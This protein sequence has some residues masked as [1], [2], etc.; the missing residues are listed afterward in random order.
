M[1][2]QAHK[3]AFLSIQTVADELNLN[4]ETVRKAVLRGEIPS[5]R[6]GRCYRI[7][8]EALDAWKKEGRAR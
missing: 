6:I 5:V 4:P 3:N 2:I 1:T 7:P 8:R